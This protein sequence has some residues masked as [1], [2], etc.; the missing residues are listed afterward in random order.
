MTAVKR[1]PRFVQ[2]PSETPERCSVVLFRDAPLLLD[3]GQVVSDVRVAYHAYGRPS[4][5]AVLVLH[6]LTGDSAVHQWWPAVFGRGKALD[7]DRQFIICSNVLGGCA[8]SSEPAELGLGELTL[9]DMVRVQR[10]LL[11]FLGV[12][13]VSVVGGSMGGMLAYAWLHSFPDLIT[14]AVMI[15][16]PARHSPWAIGLN[17]AARSAILAAPG[18]EGLKVARQIAMLSYRSPQSFAQTQAGPSSRQAGR[19][20][21]STY[22]EY[23]GQKLA[24]RFCERSYLALTHAMDTF[25]LSDAD[26]KLIGTPALVVGISSDQL[27]PAS[28]VRAQAMN[29]QNVQYWQLESPHGHDAFLMDGAQMN[30]VVENFLMS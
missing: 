11:R 20:A 28:E 9:R 1:E 22:L 4:T 19:A 17:T 27:Y 18:G 26:L 23:Q 13:K 25:E 10:E 7:P 16:A 6:A 29:L 3:S 24:E 2:P 21:I 30:E 15:G 5:D 14:K 8:G 12:E